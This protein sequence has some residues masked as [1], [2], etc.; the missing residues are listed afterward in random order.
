[1]TPDVIAP[2]PDPLPPPT[3]E[4]K[5]VNPPVPTK[6]ES[7]ED[8]TTNPTSKIKDSLKLKIRRWAK[9]VMNQGSG[10]KKRAES[11]FHD[12]AIMQHERHKEALVAAAKNPRQT[13]LSALPKMRDVKKKDAY[14]EKMEKKLNVFI[15]KTDTRLKK[16]ESWFGESS[17]D[18]VNQKLELKAPQVS[19]IESIADRINIVEDKLLV[20]HVRSVNPLQET[21]GKI[22]KVLA[23]ASKKL[24]ALEAGGG[25]AEI[26]LTQVEEVSLG[27]GSSRREAAGGKQERSR[28][29]ATNQD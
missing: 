28:S 8:Q 13:M 22:K 25:K 7:P 16:L 20:E 5:K 26:D 4:E 29:E 15:E 6:T 14:A 2:S 10:R 24:G 27:E 12:A 18:V 11:M 21:V 3:S 17:P 23:D 9:S 19:T 1:V